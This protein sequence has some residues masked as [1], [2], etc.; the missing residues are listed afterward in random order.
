MGSKR[1]SAAASCGAAGMT[2]KKTP[3]SAASGTSFSTVTVSHAAALGRS[4]AA[5]T[6]LIAPSTS[7]PKSAL[8]M[9]AAKPSE[10]PAC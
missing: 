4:P 3:T 2:Q 1:G 7:T 8:A 5:T 6:T 9:G 10:G